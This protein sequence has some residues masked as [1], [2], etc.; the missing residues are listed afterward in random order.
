[1]FVHQIT[2]TEKKIYTFQNFG[3]VVYDNF[4]DLSYN[5]K[6]KHN[7]NEIMKII[8][9]PESVI[10]IALENNKMIGYLIGEF[11]K[12]NDGRHVFYITYVFTSELFRDRG[13]ASKLM[14]IVDD[15]V[16]KNNLDGIMLTCDSENYQVYNFYLKKKFMPDLVL[17]TYDKYEIMYK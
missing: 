13:I 5:P 3:Q 14:N 16:L 12:L 8:K 2:K 7:M 9:S 4:I 10:L 6:L 17:R 15:L 11:I 1:M